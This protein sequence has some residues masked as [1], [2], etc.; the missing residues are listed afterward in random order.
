MDFSQRS[1]QKELIDR[2]DIPFD[3]IERNMRE[4]DTINAWLGGH[5]ITLD[6]FKQ[7]L[8]NRKKITICE[9]GC[10]GGD[11][12][13]TIQKWCKRKNIKVN[14]IGIDINPHCIEVAKSKFENLNARF[15]V[16][17]YQLVHFEKD[18]KT[19]IIFSSLFC[20]HFTEAE[21]L[22]MLKWMES[23]SGI[24]FF[25]NDLHRHPFAFYSIKRLTSIFSKSWLVKNDAPLSVLRG[26]TRKEW[27]QLLN[28]SFISTYS[29]KWKWAFRWLVIC[30][31]T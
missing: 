2:E 25:I 22:T 5:R 29:I 20:H 12:L 4:L 6:G 31:I 21:L 14:I 1:Y 18:D 7:L 9:I 11:N 24:G 16:S 15:I 23:N 28:Q 3:A 8:K 26:F 17:D 30:H 19:D 10:G 13:K 27:Q